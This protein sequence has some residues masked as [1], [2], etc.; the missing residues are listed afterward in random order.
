MK[1]EGKSDLNSGH[2]GIMENENMEQVE[3]NGNSLDQA[4]GK[5]NEN[6]RR[7]SVADNY[8]R[9]SRNENS[10]RER[11]TSRHGSEDD[12]EDDDEDERRR[13]GGGG[14]VG[15]R[16]PPS[17]DDFYK[18]SNP[19]EVKRLAKFEKM[20]ERKSLEAQNRL[21]VS[22]L[23][24]CPSVC[25]SVRLT[26]CPS[27]SLSICLSVC[28]VYL[29]VYLSVLSVCESVCLSVRLYCLYCQYVSL[30]VGLFYSF[31][32]N[33]TFIFILCSFISNYFY[34]FIFNLIFY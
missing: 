3:G 25:L 18:T 8:E 6:G 7:K 32:D 33:I 30:S 23:K 13:G 4:E 5:G 28:T 27:V 29:S 31:Y 20:K 21:L 19:D 9:L 26:I 10:S 22:I 16:L 15:D 17:Q 11:R 1:D 24:F 14:G 12:D 34:L 2:R